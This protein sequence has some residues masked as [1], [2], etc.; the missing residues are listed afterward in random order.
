MSLR[1]SRS[2]PGAR[3]PLFYNSRSL[4]IF[5]IAVTFPHAFVIGRRLE[6]AAQQMLDSV[7]FRAIFG[8]RAHHIGS[9]AAEF[10]VVKEAA[11]ERE[12][13]SGDEH[14]GDELLDGFVEGGLNGRLGPGILFLDGDVLIGREQAPDAMGLAVHDQCDL[15]DHG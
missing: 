5:S 14:L 9:H 2:G 15:D 10:Y 7:R 8:S 1:C 12:A 3:P 6:L 11:F 13:M 4:A